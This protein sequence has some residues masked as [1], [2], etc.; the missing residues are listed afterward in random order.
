MTKPGSG[1]GSKR[2][3]KEAG[4]AEK[5]RWAHS[6]KIPKGPAPETSVSSEAQTPR[7]SDKHKRPKKKA[8]K[9]GS[10]STP[11]KRLNPKIKAEGGPPTNKSSPFSDL[12]ID[13]WANYHKENKVIPT[14]AERVEWEGGLVL[15]QGTRHHPLIAFE[16]EQ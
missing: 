1:K 7:K 6:Y 16:A 9:K 5:P 11:K 8:A 4:L 2:T 15:F 13:H 14:N 3:G 12:P 10:S